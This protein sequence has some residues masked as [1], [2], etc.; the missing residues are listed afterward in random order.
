MTG[1]VPAAS[2]VDAIAHFLDLGVLVGVVVDGLAKASLYIMI[3]AGLSL[4]FGLMGVLNFAHGSL[5]AIGAY[6]GG[7]VV[8]LLVAQASGDFARLG[9]FF[10]AVVV[11]F[12]LL[13][14]FGSLLEV[15]LIRPLYDRPPLYQ[16]LL[17]FGITLV[18]EELLRMVLHF[19]GIQP[20][21]KWQEPLGTKPSFLAPTESFSVLGT[22]IAGL[23][24]FQILFG[25][26]VTAGLWAFLTRTRYGLYI[27][28][29]SEDSEMA[30][31]LGI[32]IR[33]AF[34][35]VFGVGVGVTGVAGAL[36]MWDVAWAAQIS[37][38]AEVLLPAFVVVIVGGLGTFR[39]TVAAGVLVGLVDAVTT[40]LFTS[41]IVGFSAL[42]QLVIFLI[43]VVMLVVRP[44]GLYG[45]EE[46]GGH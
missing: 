2:L 12:A 19:Y 11:V 28:A 42:P 18:L 7:L 10:V 25:V 6:L 9:A 35:V 1:L 32:D 13:T 5:T 38:G 33:R 3:A 8:V 30:E 15:K 29:G 34:T 43:L 36:L 24:L 16:I 26:V 17:T 39:G 44:Q 21:T 27:R 41:D 31:A 14:G 40:E 45:V 20:T 46:V 4:I 22:N 37:L 23:D